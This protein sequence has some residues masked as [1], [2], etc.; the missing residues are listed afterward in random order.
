[1][2]WDDLSKNQL[3]WPSVEQVHQYRKQVYAVVSALIS[4][5]T[6]QQLSSLDQKSPLWALVMSF[7][8][9]RIHLE[10]S[11]YLMT[12]MPEQFLRLPASFPP[13]HPSAVASAGSVKETTQAPVEGEDYPVNDMIAVPHSSVTIGKPRDFPSFGWDNE[14]G[15]RDY[16]VP[17]FKASKFL[18]TNGEFHEFMKDGGYNSSNFWSEAGWRWKSYRNAKN[19]NLWVRTGPQGHHEYDLRLIF[20][21]V[22]MQWDWPVT[23]NFHEVNAL[24]AQP[25]FHR[26]VYYSAIPY[27]IPHHTKPYHTN[28]MPCH[29]T[30]RPRTYRLRPSRTGVRTGRGVVCA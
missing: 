8:H 28:A 5:L 24:P 25:L 7:E 12:E 4:S 23:V 18:V 26:I 27:K 3:S 9:E 11:S 17:A 21:V 20:D 30:P 1:M 29:A 2:S 10:T 15:Q 19:P 16:S 22:P 14:Y 6:E 13:Y